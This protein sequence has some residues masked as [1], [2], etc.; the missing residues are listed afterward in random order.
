MKAKVYVSYAH[1]QFSAGQIT[2]ITVRAEAW[3]LVMRA[4]YSPSDDVD[5]D[6][7]IESDNEGENVCDDVL[8]KLKGS[9]TKRVHG[10]NGSAIEDNDRNKKVK[11]EEEPVSN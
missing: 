10:E 6:C 11:H 3:K 7:A 9:G 2:G 8:L 5:S 4:P 1:V